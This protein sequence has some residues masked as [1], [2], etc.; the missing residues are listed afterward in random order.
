M[1][2]NYYNIYIYIHTLNPITGM[3]LQTIIIS[4]ICTIQQYIGLLSIQ[5]SL[6]NIH[7]KEILLYIL[8]IAAQC[9]P[10]MTFLTVGNSKPLPSIKNLTSVKGFFNGFL[11]EA[12]AFTIRPP[13]NWT[14]SPNGKHI[15]MINYFMYLIKTDRQHSAMLDSLSTKDL[16]TSTQLRM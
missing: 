4:Y 11:N 7:I 5:T 1:Y 13:F 12:T 2:I 16:D 10:Y 8:L 6:Y 14:L 9:F 15:K 3:A